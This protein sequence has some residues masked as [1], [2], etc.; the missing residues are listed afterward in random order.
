ML[1]NFLSKKLDLSKFFS[2]LASEV[3]WYVAL[4]EV[5]AMSPVQPHS[6]VATWHSVTQLWQLTDEQSTG[7]VAL[8]E[9][10]VN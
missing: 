5:V 8:K 2:Y 4:S 9:V 3:R 10:R 7:N 6:E 1:T